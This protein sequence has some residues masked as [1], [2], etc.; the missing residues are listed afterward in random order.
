MERLIQDL[1]VDPNDVILLVLS[2]KWKAMKP[3]EFEGKSSS[4]E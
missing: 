1:G 2:W 4:T 3:L